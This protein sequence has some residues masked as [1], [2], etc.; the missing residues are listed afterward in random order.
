MHFFLLYRNIILL[1]LLQIF[2]CNILKKTNIYLNL[3]SSL[4]YLQFYVSYMCLQCVKIANKIFFHSLPT[5]REKKILAKLLKKIWP[6]RA[7]NWP[8]LK[9]KKVKSQSRKKLQHTTWQ[10]FLFHIYL[11]TNTQ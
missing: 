2:G 10:A 6:L 5:F 3:N 9:G 11:S 8:Q 1:N 7:K 4:T